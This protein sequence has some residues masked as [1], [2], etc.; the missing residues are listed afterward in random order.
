MMQN[1]LEIIDQWI[2]ECFDEPPPVPSSLS[3]SDTNQGLNI[4]LNSST[5]FQVRYA[6]R[7]NVFRMSA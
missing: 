1:I 4:Q 3:K 7:A 6:A 2:Q 5:R